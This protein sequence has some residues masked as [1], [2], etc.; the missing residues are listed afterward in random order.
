MRIELYDDVLM[1]YASQRVPDSV[2]KALSYWHRGQEYDEKLH[3]RVNT[4]EVRAL[5]TIDEAG[6][7]LMTLPGFCSDIFRIL[8]AGTEFVD[9]RTN[10]VKPDMEAGMVNLR[11]YQLEIAYDAI[12]ARGGIVNCA[13]GM[14]K[15]LNPDT[16]VRYAE[17]GVGPI[18][19]VR[20]GDYLVDEHGKPTEVLATTTGHGPMYR[21]TQ[22]NGM[23]F[24]AHEGHI[25]SLVHS[26]NG[27]K[28]SIKLCDYIKQSKNFKHLHKMYKE[29]VAYAY[30]DT[31]V[32]PYY[33]GVWLGDGTWSTP[34][35]TS[36][37]PEVVEAIYAEAHSRG[38]T[39]HVNANHT[40]A[41]CPTYR[42]HGPRKGAST[43][44]S[45]PLTAAMR[46]V[47]LLKE[48]YKLIPDV[49]KYNCR[50]VR[51]AVL[52]GILDTDGHLTN[53]CYDWCTT[54]HSYAQ[55]VREL[56]HGLGFR[57]AYNEALVKG[58]G[59]TVTRYRM[60]IS[61]HTDQIPT[62]VARKQ[63]GPRKQIKNVLRSG[64]KVEPI[65]DG[66]YAGVSLGGNQLYQLED[67]TVTHNT[68][69]M[70]A[71]CKA[72]PK[73]H[74]RLTGCPMTVIVTPTKD[75]CTK[76]YSAIKAVL[77]DRHVGCW[78]SDKKEM[79]DDILV[80][81]PESLRNKDISD[82]GLLIYD[83]CHTLSPARMQ[84]VMKAQ[85]AMRYGFSATPEG[86]SDGSDLCVKGTFGPEV[87]RK[88]Y[89]DGVA[90]GALVPIKVIWL[91]LP[92]PQYNWPKK[93]YVN[94]DHTLKKGLWQNERFHKLVK[95]LYD[96]LPKNRQQ[97]YLADTVTHI[98]RL[99]TE[100]PDI[101]VVHAETSAKSIKERGF[102]NV[103]AISK[104]NRNK[105]YSSFEKKKINSIL[106][107]G[108][109]RTGVDFPDLEFCV[110]LAGRAS[111]IISQQLPGRASRK[112]EGKEYSYTIDFWPKWDM[113]QDPKKQGE[114]KAGA[115]LRD[116][117]SRRKTYTKLGFQQ[118][119]INLVEELYDICGGTS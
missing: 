11:D 38:L 93:E 104:N 82:C 119:N 21:I 49:Y 3:R 62:R 45:N 66:P 60:T 20:V 71:I 64:F 14:G 26:S 63:A 97:L 7:T 57:V 100:L 5:Y 53:N 18:G 33:I 25:L 110:N 113:V 59:K 56:V 69:I 61:G 43:Y 2:T 80:I 84:T 112:T 16:R 70:M 36:A 95:E 51:L 75:L 12:V 92:Y 81:T 83:E 107:S 65:G 118:V 72:Y 4:G 111:S 68:Y 39:V 94:K 106:S 89:Q 74:L 101:K 10:N 102:K 15:C 30:R 77:T 29:P 55:E 27:R 44:N 42:I 17:G 1:V 78:N 96:F 28:V 91:P 67:G 87:V 105:L 73:E 76:N 85:K 103:E 54:T 109:Y 13:T 116:A 99:M 117:Q 114:L 90:C 37:D 115:L 9:K 34:S 32:D 41:H 98:D 48:K 22:V 88:T 8:G 46:G 19:D 31:P 23:T 52:A 24:E 79:S 6:T 40:C 35:V 86:R 58:F 47:G 50:E 108:I